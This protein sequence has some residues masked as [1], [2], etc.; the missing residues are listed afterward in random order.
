MGKPT[1]ECRELFDEVVEELR[2][3]HPDLQTGSF[4][5]SWAVKI[6]TKPFACVM[7]EIA[8]FRLSGAEGDAALALAGAGPFEPMAGRRM[9][10]W[11]Q[12]PL[13]QS[14]EWDALAEQAYAQLVAQLEP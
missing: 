1:E 7:D 8:V 4:F 9:N 2:V 3:R 10:G 12:V 5:S 14:A 11:V 6:G 13:A